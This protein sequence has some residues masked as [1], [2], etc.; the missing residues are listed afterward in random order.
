MKNKTAQKRGEE[1][2]LVWKK[3]IF[4]IKIMGFKQRSRVGGMYLIL[5]RARLRIG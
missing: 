2:I 1:I 5:T 4:D 3:E